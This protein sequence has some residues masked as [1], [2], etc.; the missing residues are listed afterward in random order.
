MTDNDF[1]KLFIGQVLS[2][3]LSRT[4]DRKDIVTIAPFSMSMSPVMARTNEDGSDD[5]VECRG[6][7]PE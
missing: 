6:S 3:N 4:G 7:M 5:D 2:A 1:D